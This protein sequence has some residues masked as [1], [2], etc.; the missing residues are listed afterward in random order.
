MIAMVIAIDGG[1]DYAADAVKYL[2]AVNDFL[3]GRHHH[4]PSMRR[5]PCSLGL[6]TWTTIFVDRTHRQMSQHHEQTKRTNTAN[7]NDTHTHPKLQRHTS[8][9]H[10][11]P[12]NS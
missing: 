6:V 11:V 3:T 9:P 2:E 4:A 8:M 7:E 1:T 12:K 10:C 5:S